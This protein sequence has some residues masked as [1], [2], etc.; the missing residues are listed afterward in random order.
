MHSV[1]VAGVASVDHAA[2]DVGTGA[3]P[4]RLPRAGGPVIAEVSVCGVGSVRHF[5]RTIEVCDPEHH[6]L[7]W[8]VSSSFR[9]EHG[10][11]STSARGP[12]V[13]W[14]PA[15]QHYSLV[16]NGAVGTAKFATPTCPE[17][18]DAVVHLHLDA[19]VGPLLTFAADDAGRAESAGLF[20][21]VTEQLVMAMEQRTRAMPIPRDPAAK[22]VARRLLADPGDRR[23]LRD[24]SAQVAVSERTLRRR[25]LEETGLAFT[26]WRT[27]LRM[28][29]AMEMLDE[30]EPVE[31][32]A[33][34]CGYRSRVS[35]TRAFKAYSGFTPTAYTERRISPTKPAN[36]PPQ[37]P[38]WPPLLPS[39]A[40]T[41]PERLIDALR[42]EESMLTPATRRAVVLAAS[43]ILT[44]AACGDA[45]D[46]EPTGATEP[47]TT[48]T[49]PA[50]TSAST[51]AVST[52]QVDQGVSVNDSFAVA[53][54]GELGPAP[55]MFE[56]VE[57]RGDTLVVTHAFGE[58]EIPAD[59]QRI[60]SDASMLP[61]V[62]ELDLNWIGA[63]YYNDS[64]RLPDW[65]ED[66]ASAEFLNEA[67][68]QTNF[69]AVAALEPDL[70][71]AYGDVFWGSDD[72][73]G[74]Y[75]LMSQVAPTL[76]PMGDPVA[77]FQT[78]ALELG[79]ALGFDAD[80]ITDRI[81]TKTREIVDA[82]A[83]MREAIGDE[84]V[85]YLLAQGG[86]LFLNGI[87]YEAEDGSLAPVADSRW[88]YEFCGFQPPDSLID[89]VGTE[90]GASISEELLPSIDADHLFVISSG[91]SPDQR[92]SAAQFLSD[93]VDSPIWEAIPAVEAG[94]VYIMEYFSALSFDTA[95]SA[96]ASANAAFAASG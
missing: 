59:P 29:A 87:G 1:A 7:L 53:G 36:R 66:T 43:L 62:I 70:I 42:E 74:H 44:A 8:P 89:V 9:V 17:R 32:A 94:N 48:T 46:T 65:E 26:A 61:T 95:S 34:R 77:Y 16:A 14:V 18:W 57:D 15:G 56:L 90:H 80:E 85:A 84:T 25:F 38:S 23:E 86:E 68:Y 5:P 45:D 4:L 82:C 79:V 88:L 33:R 35:F 78:L 19:V 11:R 39:T 2:T 37:H 12:S 52:A 63:E 22:L 91:Y 58:V 47:E 55:T 28:E 67:T 96:I 27:R 31:S 75:E 64:V 3:S 83:P 40:E 81:A 72:P 24:W 60:F 13:I 21:I 92:E 20:S 30:G 54:F 51:P 76:V 71:M 50:G 73:E 10:D 6:H 49:G 69:E 93:L 41:L